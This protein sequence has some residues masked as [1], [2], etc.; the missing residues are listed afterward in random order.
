M[1]DDELIIHIGADGKITVE[2]IEN[3]V[4]AYKAVEPETF[5]ECV[6][7][8]ICTQLV[9]SGIM[10]SGTF[11]FAAVMAGRRRSAWSFN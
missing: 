1:R 6:R 11:Y 5:I 4:H 8:S 2:D 10:P 9:S 7:S 3:G